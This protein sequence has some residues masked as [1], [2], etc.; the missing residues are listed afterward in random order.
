MDKLIC[1]EVAAREGG[2]VIEYKNNYK[3]LKSIEDLIVWAKE[4]GLYAFK[5]IIDLDGQ[6]KVIPYFREVNFIAHFN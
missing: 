4:C 3:H 6:R 2:I 1:L 5:P